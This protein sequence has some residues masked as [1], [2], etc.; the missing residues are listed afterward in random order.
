MGTLAGFDP[1]KQYGYWSIGIIISCAYEIAELLVSS[2]VW[3]LLVGFSASTAD[4]FPVTGLP[5]VPSVLIPAAS[6]CGL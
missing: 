4:I 2:H 3:V 1:S 5:Q 6:A